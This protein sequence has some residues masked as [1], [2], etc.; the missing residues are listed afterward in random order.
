VVVLL[1]VDAAG[2]M[3]GV[4]AGADGLTVPVAPIAVSAPLAADAEA[5]VCMARG[6]VDAPVPAGVAL[7]PAGVAAG[8]EAAA[9]V[10]AL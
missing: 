9:G 8:V 7:A 6:P 1:A 4:P 5:S 2:A 3:V 10:A